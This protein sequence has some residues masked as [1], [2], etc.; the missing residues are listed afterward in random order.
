MDCSFIIVSKGST[1][2]F[3][4]NTASRLGGAIYVESCTV[5]LAGFDNCFIRH[6]NSALHPDDWG[7]NVTFIDNQ[8][9]TGRVN[10]IYMDLVKSCS[11]GDTFCWRGWWYESSSGF[12]VNCI[13]QLASGPAY[14]YYR[15]TQHKWHTQSRSCVVFKQESGTFTHNN[16]AAIH[17]VYAC[18]MNSTVVNEL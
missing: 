2:L 3:K 6:T 7:I 8:L 15:T 11:S 16:E 12:E 9:G 5:G 14:N 10:A 17:Q 4:H 18:P 13:N 1:L